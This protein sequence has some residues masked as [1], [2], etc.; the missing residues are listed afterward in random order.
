MVMQ[1]NK[2]IK[3]ISIIGNDR[4]KNAN[5]IFHTLSKM[6][7]LR[8]GRF[9]NSVKRCGSNVSDVLLLLVLMPFYQFKSVPVLVKSGLGTSSGVECGNSV[10]YDLKNNPKI[11]WRSLLYLIALRFKNL[12]GQI[13]QDVNKVRAFIFDDTPAPKSGIKTELVSRVHDHVSG[14]F[15]LGYKIL[16]M[17][18]WDGLSFYPLDFSI[19]REKG[20]KIDDVKERLATA[21]K[22]LSNQRGVVKEYTKS[23]SEFQ[24]AL[25]SIRK[26][27][28]GK[29]TKTA[30]NKIETAKNKVGRAKQKLRLAEA[31]YFELENKAIELRA[32]LTETK[33]R[34]PHYDLTKKQLSEQA[35]KH[36][37]PGTPGAQRAEEADI[38]KTT[39]MMAM[40]KRAVKRKFEAD[41]VLTDSWFFNYE[42]VK[43]V[44]ILY[45]KCKLNLISMARIGTIKYKLTA[46]DKYY[47]AF[48]L[49]ARFER[50]AVNARSHKAKYI[51]VPVTFG[52]I[53]INLFFIKLGQSPNW[54]LLATTDLAINFQKLMDIYQIRWSIELFFREGKQYLSL[55][56]SKS[57]CF[58]TQIADATISMVQYTILSFHRRITDYSSFDGIFAS[59]MEDAMQYSI[60]SQLQKLVLIILDFFADFTGIDV[61]ELT[62]SVFRDDM[63]SEKLIKLNRIFYENMEYLDAA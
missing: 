3:N 36:R 39:S 23:L 40:L 2:G 29:Q 1:Q 63:A 51:K 4:E 5:D 11:D 24:E 45:E 42:L 8:I 60:A 21:N 41:Y 34:H 28:K 58:D 44:S 47:N 61:I 35:K 17:G 10:F 18:Y 54:H 22:R 15:I 12:A 48:E 32:E 46:T 27:N 30:K 26:E 9:F 43:L 16:V 62:R 50:K 7:I 14:R 13:N 31:K 20:G 52:D 6:K 49:L 25:K 33:K 19:H 55:G 38:K 56:K 53:R 59:A 37:D 57:T